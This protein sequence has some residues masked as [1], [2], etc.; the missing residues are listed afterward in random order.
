MDN[1]ELTR[2]DF[3]TT[4]A[5]GIVAAAGADLGAQQVTETNVDIK[6]PDGTCDAAFIHPAS[7]CSP[8]GD[9]LARR[10]RPAAVDARDGQAPRREWIFGARAEPVLSRR[11]V[12][13]LGGCV[14]GRLPDRAA[15]DRAADG[16]DQGRRHGREGRTSLHRVARHAAAGRS[17]QE[18]RHAGLLHGRRARC[19]DR[20]RGAEPRRRG[21]LVPRWRSRD[22]RTRTAR[23]CWRRRSKAACT[24]VS[25]PTTTCS[26][27][28]P[29][30]S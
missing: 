1:D 17:Q 16:I 18:D 4:V 14:E 29:R 19:Q 10:I 25:R 23:I 2:R 7:R 30:P 24:S 28:M 11:E 13:G 22:A 12:A 6:T 5:A 26:S 8:G 21:R 9:R 3:V 15:E 20:S 27:P